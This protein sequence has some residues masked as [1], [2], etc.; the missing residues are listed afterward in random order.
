VTRTRLDQEVPGRVVVV[1][2]LLTDVVVSLPGPLPGALAPGSDT[3][4]RTTVTGG[5]SA[6]NVAAW[7]AEAGVP[8]TLVTRVGDDAAGRLLTAEL[9][10]GGVEVRAA[11]DPR[12]PTGTV[13]VLVDP[14]GERTMLPD[15]G[16]SG[17]LAAADL[18]A[19]LAAGEVRH[20][21]LSGYVLLDEGCRPAGLHALAAARRAGIGTSVGAGSAAPLRAAGATRFLDWVAG[22]DLLVANSAEAAVLAGDQAAAGDRAGA[23]QAAPSAAQ[24]AEALAA[25]TAE[26]LAARAAEALAARAAEALTARTGSAVVVTAG[27][28]GAVWADATG[29]VRQ[30]APVACSPDS[31][32][33]GDAFTAG[34]LAALLSGAAPAAA[35]RGGVELARACLGSVGGRPSPGT[36]SVRSR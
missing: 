5:G 3:P 25:R 7:L 35:L 34:L 15:R 27:A 31:T 20:L 26:A 16:A 6:A 17:L 14:D 22:S 18:D 11:V 24:P 1:G 32:G 30:G 29:S 23:G 2:D 33:A 19:A 28:A 8:T 4:S 21:H 13:V 36:G 12:V 9:R 10:D